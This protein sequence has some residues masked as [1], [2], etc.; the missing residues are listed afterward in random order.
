M[1]TVKCMH[2]VELEEAERVKEEFAEDRDCRPH[3]EVVIS[4]AGLHSLWPGKAEAL[5]SWWEVGGVRRRTSQ[6]V[7]SDPSRGAACRD[8]GAQRPHQVEPQEYVITV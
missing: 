1:P 8:G 5:C 7:W 3:Q 2:T 4:K 6:D